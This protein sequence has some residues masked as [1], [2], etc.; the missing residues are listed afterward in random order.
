M[1][2][3]VKKA[4]I[5]LFLDW[6]LVEP[7]K[8]DVTDGGVILP[9]AVEQEGVGR[10]RVIAVGPGKPD[11]NGHL[12]PMPLDV[13]DVVFTLG[14]NGTVVPVV[15]DKTEYLLMQAGAMVGKVPS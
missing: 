6:V 11:N 2:A 15:L 14:R 1:V 13:G 5:E 4:P 10:A 7:I 8:K 3:S 12:L 9:D